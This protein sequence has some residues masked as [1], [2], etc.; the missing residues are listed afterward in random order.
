MPTAGPW[1]G[2]AAALYLTVQPVKRRPYK[3][4][5]GAPAHNRRPPTG[6]YTVLVTPRSATTFQLEQS[7]A[8]SIM[9][10]LRGWAGR[11]RLSALPSSRGP[12]HSP[13]K[14]VTPVRIRLGAPFLSSTY[15]RSRR[16][17]IE[18]GKFAESFALLLV[19][20]VFVARC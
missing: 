12:G 1:A 8:L 13:L 4:N 9:A 18:C 17:K 10:P 20:V 6:G 15:A 7:G 14:A 19:L 16:S 2:G 5:A 11:N 3:A